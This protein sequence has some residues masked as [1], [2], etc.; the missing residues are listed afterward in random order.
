M[1]YDIFIYTFK[2]IILIFNYLN[3]FNFFN[4]NRMFF[5]LATFKKAISILGGL[6]ILINNAEVT[7]EENF[8]KAVDINVVSI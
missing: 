1:V 6:D 7:S 4:L 5:F 8:V 3:Y 2:Y